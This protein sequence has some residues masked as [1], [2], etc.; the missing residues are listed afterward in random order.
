MPKWQSWARHHTQVEEWVFGQ[1][2]SWN[3]EICESI[4]GNCFKLSRKQEFC[5]NSLNIY[6][7]DQ[8]VGMMFQAENHVGGKLSR[9]SS[10]WTCSAT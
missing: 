6:P 5:E 10:F 2:H 7:K 3:K 1:W 8:L 9:L 4:S